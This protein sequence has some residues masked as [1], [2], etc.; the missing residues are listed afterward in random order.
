VGGVI[1]G[2]RRGIGMIADGT[3]GGRGM[4]VGETVD[5]IV[6]GIEMG[7]ESGRGIVIEDVDRLSR[8]LLIL[9]K[10]RCIELVS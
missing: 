9:C 10:Y 1:G 7:I 3:R 6:E 2:R 5:G 8:S 4:I